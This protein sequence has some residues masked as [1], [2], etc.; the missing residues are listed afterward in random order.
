M[1][2]RQRL[3]VPADRIAAETM[4]GETVVIDLSTGTY[5]SLA[6]SASDIWVLTALGGTVEEAASVLAKRYGIEAVLLASDIVRLQDQLVAANLLV[7]TDQP[8]ASLEGVELDPPIGGYST[9]E[10]VTYDDMAELLAL[11][12]PLPGL[13]GMP[14]PEG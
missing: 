3:G 13:S 10:L 14:S 6:G 2:P 11:D 5:H 9:P 8:A 4:D 1:T 12:P 7:P